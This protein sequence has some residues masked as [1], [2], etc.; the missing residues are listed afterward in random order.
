MLFVP[1]PEVTMRAMFQSTFVKLAVLT[2]AVAAVAYFAF[3]AC[4][5]M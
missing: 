4:R 1:P 5:M 3:G 2:C